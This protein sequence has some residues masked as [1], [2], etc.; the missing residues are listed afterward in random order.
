MSWW[1]STSVF[2]STI[3]RWPDFVSSYLSPRWDQRLVSS[4]WGRLLRWRPALSLS[5]VDDVVW[6]LITA[7]ESVALVSMLGFFFLFC[8]CTIWYGST[9]FR[10][11]VF[12]LACGEPLSSLSWVKPSSLFKYFCLVLVRCTLVLFEY[13][14]SILLLLNIF[15]NFLSCSKGSFFFW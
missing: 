7:F 1:W 5:I 4:N 11:L 9:T 13:Y 3:F 14:F 6:S 12:Y 10:I 2:R 8:G 15:A